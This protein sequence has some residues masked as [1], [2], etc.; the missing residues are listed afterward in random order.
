MAK[1][2]AVIDIGSNSVRMVIYEKTS[3]FAFHILHESKSRVRISQNAYKHDGNLQPAAMDRAFNALHSFTQIITQHKANKILCVA[4]SALR[5]APNQAEF[6]SRVK[7]LLKLNIKIISGEKEAYLGGL[8]A[9]NLLHLQSGLCVD[10]G[11]GSTELA[12]FENNQV[13][14]TL[15][16]KLGTVRLKELFF[17]N[18]DLEGA[19]AYI[20]EALKS[21]PESFFHQHIVGIGGTLRA[22][23][24]MIIQKNQYAYQRLH[25]FTYDYEDEKA[26]FEQILGADEK[27]LK[28]LGVKR[29]RLD[30]MQ[31]GLLILHELLRHVNAKS[32]TTS[33]VGVREGLFL[34]DLLRTAHHRFPTNY[35][36]SVRSMLDRFNEHKTGQLTTNA[37]HLYDL[38]AA[39]CT[40]PIDFKQNFLYAI[41]LASIGKGIDYYEAHHH[42]YYLL[43]NGLNYG[44]SHESTLLIATLVR[45]QRKGSVTSSHFEKYKNHLPEESQLQSLCLLMRLSMDLFNDRENRPVPLSFEDGCLKLHMAEDYLIKEKLQGLLDKHDALCVKFETPSATI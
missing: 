29:E 22:L 8:A 12:Y 17:D 9:T 37:S 36:P 35:N 25:A 32:I 19:R 40:L 30:V 41:K 45:F 39:H 38:M 21:L 27:G 6:L 20:Q 10:I 24:K 13:T 43:L 2:T 18:A 23:S 44:F 11:G 34:S 7:S 3:R 1:R 5:D 4:T 26:Y 14:S 16:L 42:A 31:P 33:G 15:S 28:N